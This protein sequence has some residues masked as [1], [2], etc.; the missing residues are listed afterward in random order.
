[1]HVCMWACVCVCDFKWLDFFSR[2]VLS[3]AIISKVL[4]YEYYMK[5]SLEYSTV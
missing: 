1:M 4:L 2:Q 3:N 5:C